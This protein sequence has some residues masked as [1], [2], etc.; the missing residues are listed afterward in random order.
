MAL[1]WPNDKELERLFQA[2][3]ERFETEYDPESWNQMET[4]L[5]KKKRRGF[6]YLFFLSLGALLA[7]FLLFP[8]T[9]VGKERISS[10]R[11]SVVD[12]ESSIQ[13]ELESSGQIQN[14]D[15]I[16]NNKTIPTDQINNGSTGLEENTKGQVA[17]KQ[18][19]HPESGILDQTTLFVKES[20]IDYNPFQNPD[21]IFSRKTSELGIDNPSKE[22]KTS[23]TSDHA[24]S[25]SG[26]QNNDN[27]FQ[28]QILSIQPLELTDMNQVQRKPIPS[29][30]EIK[31]DFNAF[32]NFGFS[33][34]MDASRTQSNGLSSAEPFYGLAMKY[35][36]SPKVAISFHTAFAKDSYI[37]GRYDYKPPKG[38]WKNSQAPQQ[39]FA[40][41]SMIEVGFGVQYAL[42][43][44]NENGFFAGL[45]LSSNFMIREEY[46]YMFEDPSDSWTSIYSS[47]NRTLF[48]NLE[49]SFG[50][51]AF[52]SNRFHL[53]MAPYLEIP[54]RGIGHGNIMLGGAG[55]RLN[56]TWVSN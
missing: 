18:G 53:S 13:A 44:V 19:Q 6:V 2:G 49:F 29:I 46:Y 7:F 32:W 14:T 10:D 38:Y 40:E 5:N 50:Y 36:S 34:G 15:K 39:T 35:N 20:N 48:N 47:A 4:L 27:L 45:G 42:S 12:S 21:D 24:F 25:T 30:I 9:D 56:L 22:L 54:V 37:A 33:L 31:D 8:K 23:A 1:N 41:C 55:V 3:A 51:N 17:E 52:V 28:L 11:N 43:G 16:T 26:W